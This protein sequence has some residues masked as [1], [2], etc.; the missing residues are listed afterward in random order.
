MPM[1]PAV[2]SAVP[3]STPRADGRLDIEAQRSIEESRARR[4]SQLASHER[5]SLV[6]SNLLFALS[7]VAL[8]ML[9]PSDRSPSV[10]TVL[11]LVATYAVAFRLDFE[12]AAGNAVAT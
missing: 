8:A 7:A 3:A 1:L 12:I 5:T 4:L 2:S 9:L 10:A 6:V 11:L